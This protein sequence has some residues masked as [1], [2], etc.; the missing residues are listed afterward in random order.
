MKNPIVRL[1]ATLFLLFLAHECAYSGAWTHKR[2]HFYTK[3]GL[4]LFDSSSQYTLDGDREPLANNGRVTDL[5]IYYYLEYGIYDDLTIV[6]SVPFKRINFS[7]AIE[8]CGGTSS[9]VGDLYFGLRYRLSQAEWIVSLQ[10]GL[11]LAPGYETDEEA[12][13]SA[14]PLGDGQ[15]DVE[16]RLLFGRSILNYNGYVNIDVGYRAREGE[17]VDEVPFSLELGYNLTKDYLLIGQLQG[18]RSIS[19]KAS[20]TDFRIVDGML[21]DFVGTG[22]VEDF[23]KARLQLIYRVSPMLDL[24]FEFEQVLLGRNTSHATIVGGGIAVRK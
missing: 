19:E 8:D 10:S 11:K 18:V 14:P 2:G 6:T 13:D 12:L 1:C 9:G 21:V 17:P 24:S 7:C 23:A 16:F 4:L 15:T 5:G 22:A 20:Q 3:L